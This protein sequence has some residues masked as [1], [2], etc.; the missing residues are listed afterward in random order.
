MKGKEIRYWGFWLYRRQF[1]NIT[2]QNWNRVPLFERQKN[3]RKGTKDGLEKED[4]FM[5]EVSLLTVCF[6]YLQ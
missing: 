5:K 1:V 3:L 4:K 2:T 6:E